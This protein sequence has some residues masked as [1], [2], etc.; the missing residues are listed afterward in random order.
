MIWIALLAMLALASRSSPKSGSSENGGD[1]SVDRDWDPPDYERGAQ[2]VRDY[3]RAAGLNEEQ[4]AFLVFVSLGESGWNTAVGLGDPELAPPEV[5]IRS[6]PE[7]LAKAEADGARRAYERNRATFADCD[8]PPESYQFGSGG[9]F[10]MLP[11]YALYHL[12]N[13]PLRCASPYEVFDPA[14]AITAAYQWLRSLTRRSD[15]EGTVASLR[16]GWWSPSLMDRP[17]KYARK[18]EKWRRQLTQIGLD[19]DWLDMDSPS[20]PARDAMTMY[21]SMGGRL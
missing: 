8:W 14:F 16:A 19:P 9:L 10:A 15:F 18:V 13:T 2:M 12:R 20:F 5:T 4:T 17:D 3:C 11:T 21:R 6:T 1:A 7:S